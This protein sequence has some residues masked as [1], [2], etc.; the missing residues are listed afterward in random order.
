LNA[1]KPVFSLADAIDKGS[2]KS[3]QSSLTST[4]SNTIS[5]VIPSGISGWMSPNEV[6]PKKEASSPTTARKPVLEKIQ[7]D[8]HKPLSISDLKRIIDSQKGRELHGYSPYGAFSHLIQAYQEDWSKL[9][10]NLLNAVA[11][12]LQNLVQKIAKDIFGRFIHLSSQL[13]HLL[14]GYL[15]ELYKK[16]FEQISHLVAMERRFPFTMGSEEFNLLRLNALSDF[17][18]QLE[19]VKNHGYGVKTETIHKAIAALAEAGFTGI[20]YSII[21]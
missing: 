3:S 5:S 11:L 18:A 19:S 2:L 7:V 20:Y 12:E 10:T 6:E 8:I 13:K 21:L 17:K 1:S 16:T 4:L 9:A 14:A 15:D